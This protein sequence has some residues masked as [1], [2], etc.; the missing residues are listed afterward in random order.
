MAR[1]LTQ[2]LPSVLLITEPIKG[3]PEG[4]PLAHAH[5]TQGRKKADL[6]HA[7][8]LHLRSSSS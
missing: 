4:F 3:L 2:S 7:I 5:T 1:P 6:T 8:I